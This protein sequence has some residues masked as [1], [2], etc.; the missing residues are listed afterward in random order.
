VTDPRLLDVQDLSVSYTTRAG[1]VT[2]I[3]GLSLALNAGEAVGL[4]G[5]SGCGKSTVALA[6]MRYWGARGGSPAAGSRS[7]GAIS[8][9]SAMPSSAPSAD[10][11]SRW[12]TRTR[13]R[14]S[15][16]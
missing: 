3:P 4:V 9:H 12:C 15:I 5:E 10:C 7:R 6:I 11:A 16:R 14:A 1:E 8:P 2:V 13:W